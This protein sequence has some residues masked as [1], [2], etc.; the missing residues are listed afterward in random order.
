MTKVAFT[1][2]H[3]LAAEIGLDLLKQGVNAVDAMIA[4]A[5]AITVAYPHMNS[6]GGDGFWLIQK[7][8]SAPLAIDACGVSASGANAPY[9]TSRNYAQIPS[10]GAAANVTVGGTVAGWQLARELMSHKLSTQSKLS[11]TCLPVSS[12]LQP[13]IDLAKSGVPVSESLASASRKVLAE[14]EV[15]ESASAHSLSPILTAE[16]SVFDEYKRVFS[17]NGQPLAYVKTMADVNRLSNKNEL[18]KNPDLA[19]S[20]EQ[21]AHAGLD[22][23][24]RG[25]LAQTIGTF[26]EGMDAPL[27]TQDLQ[28]YY[29]NE[30]TPLKSTISKGELY[31]LP[32]PTQGV[33]SLLILA[34]YDELYHEGMDEAE[35]A[36]LLVEATKQAFLVRDRSICDPRRM[37]ISTQDVLSKDN[38]QRLAKNI[39]HKALSWPHVAEHGDTVWMGCVDKDGVMVSFIQSIYWEFGSAVV[40][41]KTGI[42]WNNRGSSFSLDAAH[43]NSI[44]PQC[45]PLHTLNPALAVLHDGRRMVYG[46][47]GGEGQPQTQ[48]ALF[49]RK[50]YQNKSLKE[51]IDQGRW[52]LGRT[53]GDQNTD[54]KME[55]DFLN[56]VE[57][58]LLQKGHKIQPVPPAS[59]MMGHAGAIIL[60]SKG[61]VECASDKR[62]DG[63]GLVA[64]ALV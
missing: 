38:V 42:V 26:F 41:P 17:D 2:P 47:M 44:M 14:I 5:A 45:K 28:G 11:T 29:A 37:V 31:N 12:L 24:Y 59:E 19:S 57:S 36:H 56:D 18:F 50:F 46:T 34:I 4:A 22:D 16:K 52:L 64:S 43:H 51:S 27:G 60:D 8:G 3:A 15:L 61:D 30:V 13:A 49:T 23:F 20:L 33:A 32:A 9:F 7:P 48:A 54:L 35:S 55:R 58:T 10:R 1:A 40:I 63:A 6:V 21:L 25:D 39:S 62:S 53:W